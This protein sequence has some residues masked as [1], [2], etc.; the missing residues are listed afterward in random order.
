MDALIEPAMV[1]VRAVHEDNAMH[2]D[3]M[4]SDAERVYGDAL[5][6]ARAMVVLLAAMVRDDRTEKELLAWFRNPVEYRRLRAAG[7]NAE[8][9][10]QM[11]AMVADKLRGAA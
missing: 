5:Q 8:T 10:G 3:A 11:A 2:I 1:I 4:L 9:A 6:G 7:V